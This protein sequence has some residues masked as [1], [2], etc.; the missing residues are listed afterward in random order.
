MFD[1]HDDWNDPC[2]IGA[3]GNSRLQRITLPS[4]LR[5]LGDDTF[6]GCGRLKRVTFAEDSQLETIGHTCFYSSGIEDFLAPQNLQKIKDGAFSKCANLK[7][8]ALNE[9]LETLGEAK[10]EYCWYSN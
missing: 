2:C 9:G 7:R 3:F 1:Y 10:N 6:Y 4:T 5:E 8:V